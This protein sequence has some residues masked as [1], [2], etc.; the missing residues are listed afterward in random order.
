MKRDLSL[1][2]DDI[3][4][5]NL[6]TKDICSNWIKA[7]A[8][9][10]SLSGS[11]VSRI[12]SA[13][14]NFYKYLQHSGVFDEDA[15]SPF[16]VPKAYQVI[17]KPNAKAIYKKEPWKPFLPEQV[18]L[19]YEAAFT[20]DDTDLANLIAIAAYSGTRIEELCSLK[21]TM[22]NLTEM[23]FSIDDSKTKAG[24]RV[25]PIHPRIFV[26][27]EFLVSESSNGYIFC[28]L[29]PSKY[30]VSLK[31]H[32]KEIWTF[33]KGSRTRETSRLPFNPKNIHN[34]NGAS[35]HS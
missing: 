27:L 7:L 5:T 4:T 9:A 34:L 1:F 22:V 15:P 28:N 12:I 35:Q 24:V 29:N 31:R 2:I 18:E 32:R 19:L 10:K 6:L 30:G 16:K 20:K 25:V 13:C 11:S 26:L 17:D 14:N 8:N 21:T 3:P 33:K 23:T